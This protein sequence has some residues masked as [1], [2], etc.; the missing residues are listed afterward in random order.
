LTSSALSLAKIVWPWNA[1]AGSRN[2]AASLT[3]HACTV[4]ARETGV[5]PLFVFVFKIGTRQDFLLTRILAVNYDGV[6]LAALSRN[7]KLIHVERIEWR[8]W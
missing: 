1:A 3:G 4:F 5:E 7:G 2:S 8:V 6:F